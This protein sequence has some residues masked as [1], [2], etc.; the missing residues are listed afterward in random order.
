MTKFIGTIK[1]YHKFIG[2]R[3]RNV[4]QSITKKAKKDAG[5]ICEICNKELEL[6]AAHIHGKE[7]KQIIEAVLNPFLDNLGIVEINLEEIE[8]EIKGKHYPL[9]ETFKFLCKN[10]HNEYDDNNTFKNKNTEN[11]NHKQTKTEYMKVGEFI[12]TEMEK[13]FKEEKLTNEM[14]KNLL[15]VEY[16]KRTFN[17]GNN[18]MPMLKE[19]T[20]DKNSNLSEEEQ[21]NE[22]ITISGVKRYYK[23]CIDSKGR[24]YAICSQWY[25]DNRNQ[26]EYF[27][28]WLDSLE[29]VKVEKPDNS[30]EE[31]RIN[32]ES[33]REE[34]YNWMIEFDGKKEN[35]AYTYSFAID[36]IS[37]HY[38]E[39][40]QTTNLFDVE[41]I[42]LLKNIHN[43]YLITGKYSM[44]GE[45]G[46]GTIRNGF[47]AFIRM[48]EAKNI[49]NI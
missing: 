37:D 35:T 33:L 6:E 34:F 23:S 11:K 19:I 4:V 13:L 9:N 20:F 5:N 2:P 3:I 27:I 18:T 16:S 36:K 49:E 26:R 25:D 44:F 12:K 8:K 24:K 22:Q 28:N 47:A 30:N 32:N 1:E 41:D 48:K 21:F 38:S 45:G 14:I 43:L 46:R 31:N 39:N 15:D 10:C 7:R 29:P 17:T 40:V 42:S